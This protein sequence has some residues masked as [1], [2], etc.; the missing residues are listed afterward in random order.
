MKIREFNNKDIKSLEEFEQ[1]CLEVF[2]TFLIQLEAGEG[3]TI[4]NSSHIMYAKFDSPTK[5]SDLTLIDCNT[6]EELGK[7]FNWIWTEDAIKLIED[8]LKELKN[9][10]RAYYGDNVKIN[11]E[12]TMYKKI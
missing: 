2:T 6:K 8:K 7:T 5:G 12:S 9:L 1:E 4:E 11:I 10:A 3:M